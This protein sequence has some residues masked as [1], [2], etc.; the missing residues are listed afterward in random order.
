MP[1][2]APAEL[3]TDRLLLMRP[4]SADVD[5][6]FKRYAA[7]EEVTRFLAWPRHR[8]PEDTRSFLAFSD[9]DWER[10]GAGPYLIRRRTGGTLLGSTGFAFRTSDDVLTGYVLARDAWG[11]GYASE[12]LNAMCRV[13]ARLALPRLA[14]FCH[15][16]HERSRRVLEKCGF[17]RATEPSQLLEFPNLAPGEPQPVLR[18]V[19]TVATDP[20]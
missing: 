13:A 9:A 7:D 20:L 1:A 6:I 16:H 2:R 14:A 8:T 10:W 11:M 17:T 19:R 5:E 12:A 18:Y 4:A 15:P 3:S